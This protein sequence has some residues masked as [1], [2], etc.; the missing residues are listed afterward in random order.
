VVDNDVEAC[1][2]NEIEWEL[3][4]IKDKCREAPKAVISYRPAPSNRSIQASLLTSVRMHLLIR[5]VDVTAKQVL[6]EECISTGLQGNQG[7]WKVTGGAD[8]LTKPTCQLVWERVAYLFKVLQPRAGMQF[9]W[10]MAYAKA[11][12]DINRERRLSS[13]Q[14]KRYVVSCIL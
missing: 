14:D 3:G 1:Y 13:P 7:V 12:I 11:E 10:F 6:G 5:P 8:F 4:L 2:N 9:E